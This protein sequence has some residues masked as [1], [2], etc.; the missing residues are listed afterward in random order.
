MHIVP[1]KD[2]PDSFDIVLSG[3]MSTYPLTEDTDT[4]L[5]RPRR[6]KRKY[7]S[8]IRFKTQ[9]LTCVHGPKLL[10]TEDIDELVLSDGISFEDGMKLGYPQPF[11]SLFSLGFPSAYGVLLQEYYR[12]LLHKKYLEYESR[13]AIEG[14]QKSP[15]LIIGGNIRPSQSI[16]K[17][18]ICQFNDDD[19]FVSGITTGNSQ[20][21]RNNSNGSPMRKK[22]KKVAFLETNED[23]SQKYEEITVDQV[24]V[25]YQEGS[26]SISRQTKREN[27]V[28]RE[29]NPLQSKEDGSH[30]TENT[31]DSVEKEMKSA[32]LLPRT[33]MLAELLDENPYDSDDYDSD[34]ICLIP[35]VSVVKKTSK[36]KSDL[37]SHPEPKSQKK[38]I[39]NSKVKCELNSQVKAAPKSQR[40]TDSKLPPLLE[41]SNDTQPSKIVITR[42]SKRETRK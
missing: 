13:L 22:M 24:D 33:L 2:D 6:S 27:L 4:D 26:Q 17:R 3:L 39:T 8:L 36:S 29:I 19:L 42:R 1:V 25:N 37:H 28:K 9:K 5:F 14:P 30:K 40:K 7:I 34:Q 11:L 16:L 21:V 18:E 10:Q 23:P 12:N 38:S 15:I 32:M 41:I 35:F 31:K 20:R